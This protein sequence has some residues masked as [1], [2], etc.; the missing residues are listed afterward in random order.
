M[1][2]LF[3]TNH[4]NVGGI[5]S[6][7]FN[8][9]TG[10]KAKDQLFVASSGGNTLPRLTALGVEHL[11]V[12]LNTKNEISWKIFISALICL[13]VIKDKKIDLIHSNSRTTQ[14]LG[15]ILSRFS[16]AA[17]ISTCHGFF[18]KR[19]SRRMLPCWGDKVIAISQQV[20]EHLMRDFKVK[21]NRITLVHNGIDVA[22]FTCP[23]ESAKLNKKSELG[24]KDDIVIGILA[25]LSDVK[26]HKYLIEAMRQVLK[27]YPKAQ[28]L[29]AGEGKM[30]EELRRQAQEIG[31][32]VF[33]I[34]Q[35]LDTR[36]LLSAMDIFVMPSLNEGLGLSLMEAMSMGLA[37]IGSSVGG[38]KTLIRP[39]LNGVLVEPADPQAISQAIIDLISDKQ[40]ARH[41]G[42]NA[43]K[44][45]ENEFSLEK[46]VSNTR[47]VYL[48]CLKRKG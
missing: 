2:I 21:E 10:L 35:A 36:D 3:L 25:R 37:V 13:K 30:E 27:V 17:H 9:A 12:P 43:R 45:I 31:G 24:L 23:D 32:N 41:F 8:L 19:F 40:K 7:L 44:Y 4:L 6:Y 34:P 28:L 16:P 20:K 1:K 48:R 29:I 26:G 5:S 42:I 14:V 38:I 46:M 11:R 15:C 39:G 18:K 33:F 22:R 47:E